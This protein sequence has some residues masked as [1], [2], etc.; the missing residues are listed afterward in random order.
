[1]GSP[2]SGT[3]SHTGWQVGLWPRFPSEH[4]HPP[5]LQL[6]AATGA[7]SL[8]I[9]Q[10]GHSAPSQAPEN[11]QKPP[12]GQCRVWGQWGPSWYV[13]LTTQTSAL[14]LPVSK[15][16]QGWGQG[17]EDPAH[18]VGVGACLKADAETTYFRHT[19]PQWG[20]DAG[21]HTFCAR[22]QPQIPLEGPLPQQ[23]A[24]LADGRW[25]MRAR[26]LPLPCSVL[27]SFSEAGPVARPALWVC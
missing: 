4:T 9:G 12:G 6:R 27:A 26:G 15:K 2:S 18:R 21:S 1:M 7:G 10:F 3:G 24:P 16:V 23:V 5:L 19:V 14:G 17:T 25:V 20:L 13:G 22:G 8:G 11:L